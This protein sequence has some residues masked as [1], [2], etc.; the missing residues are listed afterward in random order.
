LIYLIEANRIQ[1]NKGG[2]ARAKDLDH[3]RG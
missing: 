1:M 2:D 3:S